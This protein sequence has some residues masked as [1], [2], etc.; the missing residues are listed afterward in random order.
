[1]TLFKVSIPIL[2]DFMDYRTEKKSI[3]LESFLLSYAKNVLF[4]YSITSLEYTN[5]ISGFWINL[6][7]IG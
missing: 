3:L 5:G 7:I 4:V 6:K 2:D 1:M